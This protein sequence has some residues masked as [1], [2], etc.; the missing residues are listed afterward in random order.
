ME[1][2][3]VD[4]VFQLPR[5]VK[6]YVVSHANEDSAAKMFRHKFD[7]EPGRVWNYQHY[8]YFEVPA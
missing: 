7:K 6:F 5:D 4:T 3:K 8:W 2:I 1:I